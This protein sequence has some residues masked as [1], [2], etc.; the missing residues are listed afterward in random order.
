MMRCAPENM[1]GYKGS[2]EA[3]LKLPQTVRDTSWV[4]PSFIVII[5]KTFP[6]RYGNTTT[7]TG[8]LTTK[9]HLNLARFQKAPSALP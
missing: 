4:T 1:K 9:T 6:K 2:A 3:W 5:P 7:T 8:A